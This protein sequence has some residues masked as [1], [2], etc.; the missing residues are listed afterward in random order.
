M[1]LVVLAKRRGI[2]TIQWPPDVAPGDRR[3]V[4][5]IEEPS[6]RPDALADNDLRG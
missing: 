1:G 5:V 3:I 4:L 2:L 6:V